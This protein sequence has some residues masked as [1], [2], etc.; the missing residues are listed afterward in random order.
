VNMREAV[1]GTAVAKAAGYLES[2]GFR[3][4]DRDWRCADGELSILAVERHTFVAFEV[5][6]WSVS[7]A[8]AQAGTLSRARQS[9]LRRLAARW[10][11]EHG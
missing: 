8:S 2:C 1:A 4:L 5:K 10:L 11:S 9:G 6:T 7:R 3:V